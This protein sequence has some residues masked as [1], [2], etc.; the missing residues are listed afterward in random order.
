MSNS[1][2]FLHQM[3]FQSEPIVLELMRMG[4]GNGI[5][6][7]PKDLNWIK[8]SDYVSKLKSSVNRDIRVLFDPQFYF[9][10]YTEDKILLSVKKGKTIDPKSLFP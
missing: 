6:L 10:H 3:G 5:I 1:V 8:I 4:I 7:S 2:E 9:P